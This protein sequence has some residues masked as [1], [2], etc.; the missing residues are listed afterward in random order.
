MA[1]KGAYTAAEIKVLE[2]LEGVRKKVFKEIGK[3]YYLR[4][5]QND[6]KKL[7]EIIKPFIHKS[8]LYKIGEKNE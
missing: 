8:M 7:I 4:F 5:K 2:G 1:E 3:Y 6:T